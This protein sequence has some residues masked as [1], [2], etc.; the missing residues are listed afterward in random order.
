MPVLSVRQEGIS[1]RLILHSLSV[2]AF[3]PSRCHYS[4]ATVR[5]S[6][7]LHTPGAPPAFPPAGRGARGEP[8]PRS[9]NAS[10]SRQPVDLLSPNRCSEGQRADLARLVLA[11]S[12]SHKRKERVAGKVRSPSCLPL[13]PDFIFPSATLYIRRETGAGCGVARL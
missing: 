7:L 13:K 11:S 9:S 6:K 10:P 12:P 3:S 8:P 5:N 4:F 2:G 1:P